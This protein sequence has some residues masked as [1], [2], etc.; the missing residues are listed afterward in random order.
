MNYNKKYLKYK[1]KYLQIKGGTIEKEFKYA[2]PTK[3]ENILSSLQML[4]ELD[5]I[6]DY[7]NESNFLEL[8]NIPQKFTIDC[9]YKANMMNFFG[10]CWFIAITMTFFFSD[11]TRVKAQQNLLPMIMKIK[12]NTLTE[13]QNK[14]LKM[15]YNDDKY[16]ENGKLKKDVIM[17]LYNLFLNLY[18]NLFLMLQCKIGTKDLCDIEINKCHLDIVSQFIDLFPDSLNSLQGKEKISEILKRYPE[19]EGKIITQSKLEI[20]DIS[21]ETHDETTTTTK[22]NDLLLREATLIFLK[23]INLYSIILLDCNIINYNLKIFSKFKLFTDDN[24]IGYFIMTPEY[25]HVF[26]IF[27]CNNTYYLCNDSVINEYDIENIS[28]DYLNYIIIPLLLNNNKN[29][30]L[31]YEFKEYIFQKR[32]ILEEFTEYNYDEINSSIISASSSASSTII[33]TT[34]NK[35]YLNIL[36]KCIKSNMNLSLDE[37]IH[38]LHLL[39]L[40][41]NPLIIYFSDNSGSSREDVP[42]EP[43]SFK[44]F[45]VCILNLTYYRALFIFFLINIFNCLNQKYEI[46]NLLL[47]PDFDNIINDFCSNTILVNDY[48]LKHLSSYDRTNDKYKI[49][50]KSNQYH[51]EYY[52][53]YSWF[54]KNYPK[55]N[56]ALTKFI[57]NHEEIILRKYYENIIEEKKN[58]LKFSFSSLWNKKKT[59]KVNIDT[60]VNA[61]TIIKTNI[62][63]YFKNDIQNEFRNQGNIKEDITLIET[64][65][66][67]FNYYLNL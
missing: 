24:I 50:F 35:I 13:N 22:I 64:F 63:H 40:S 18:K 58:Y 27:R 4:D 3:M 43:D 21:P 2:N 54:R 9:K 42:I 48:Y 30:T 36:I 67:I 45:Y 19:K 11:T 52:Y 60:K 15:I 41:I 5:K 57:T 14:L 10:T 28:I 53:H 47:N 23:Y 12:N 61:N 56:E 25:N 20:K 37:Q 51:D 26:C 6:P 7:I 1:F 46:D 59:V 16:Y 29:A 32:Y 8:A 39:H 17:I 65:A 55:I 31:N 33:L 38:L 62:Q 49:P 34:Y 66:S 44:E